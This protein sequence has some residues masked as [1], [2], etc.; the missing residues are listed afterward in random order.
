MLILFLIGIIAGLVE[1]SAGGSGLISLPAIMFFGYPP[2]EAIATSKFQYTFGALTAITRFSRAGL[3]EW[4]K[5]L[6]MLCGSMIAGGIGAYLLLL[7]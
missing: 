1:A 5:I 7:I 4:R 6:P 2:I 3:I